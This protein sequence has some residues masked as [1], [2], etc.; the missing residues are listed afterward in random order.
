MSYSPWGSK[1]SDTT[2]QLSPSLSYFQ[3]QQRIVPPY[4]KLTV[5]LLQLGCP[6][7]LTNGPFHSN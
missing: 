3:H 7:S 5:R 2:E 6:P 1:E 4:A